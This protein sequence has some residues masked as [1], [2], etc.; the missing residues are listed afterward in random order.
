M[1]LGT[2]LKLSISSPTSSSSIRSPKDRRMRGGSRHLVV[3][4]IRP[5][6]TAT[7]PPVPNVGGDY[8]LSMRQRGSKWPYPPGRAQ[9]K[10]EG[11]LES[12]E[13]VKAQ[14]CLDSASG[15]SFRSTA[16]R[17]CQEAIAGM[18]SPTNSTS[19]HGSHRDG[20]SQTPAVQR[21]LSEA[22]ARAERQV[23]IQ[24]AC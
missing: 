9:L 16:C 17:A 11:T 5:Q 22:L 14:R 10:R 21:A 20:S 13:A 8:A 7:Q 24:S 23:R 2:P 18:T 4:D 12:L 19:A 15:I 1:E 6:N 3:V